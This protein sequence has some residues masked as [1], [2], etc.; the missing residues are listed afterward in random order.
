[1]KIIKELIKQF[2]NFDEWF[3]TVRT[4]SY[5]N[6]LERLIQGCDL[7]LEQGDNL[8]VFMNLA[9]LERFA[10]DLYS[11]EK[12]MINRALEEK[13]REVVKTA[14]SLDY[15]EARK[16][17]GKLRSEPI[18][19]KTMVSEPADRITLTYL[20]PQSINNF[21]ENIKDLIPKDT[22]LISLSHGATR[23]GISLELG[24]GVDHLPIRLSMHKKKDTYPHITEQELN[25]RAEGKN[26]FVFDE[27]V[28][29]GIT[30]K[31]F[32]EFLKSQGLSAEYGSISTAKK[33]IYFKPEHFLIE[34]PLMR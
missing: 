24:L 33:P 28:A 7:V 5:N 19:F 9:R 23:A 4:I 22:L 16:L 17:L 11:E 8:G 21:Y 1:M 29:S 3:E 20:Y 15:E 14:Y 27:D 12:T 31:T 6:R 32:D 2:N 18:N 30:L 34:V 25:E 13:I 26:L 10:I